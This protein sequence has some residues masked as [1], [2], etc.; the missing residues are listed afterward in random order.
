MRAQA[1]KVSNNYE[2]E[3][4]EVPNEFSDAE[5]EDGGRGS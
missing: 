2:E 5:F 1:Y 4:E 3:E